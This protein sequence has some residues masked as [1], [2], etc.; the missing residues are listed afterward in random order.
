MHLWLRG[1]DA[2]DAIVELC[3]AQTSKLHY[4]VMVVGWK[5]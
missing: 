2:L 3:V 4:A 5:E 1:M